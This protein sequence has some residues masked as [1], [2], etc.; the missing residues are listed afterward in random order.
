MSWKKLWWF[1]WKDDSFASLLVNILIA[2]VLIKFVVYPILGLILGTSFPVVAVVSCSMQHDATNCWAD[3][4]LKGQG[5]L[6]YCMNREENLCGKNAEKNY[7]GACGEWYENKGIT[8]DEFEEFPQKN[9]FNIGDI[10]VLKKAD[11]VEI[12]DVIVYNNKVNN[13][14][15]I[16][17]VVDI[18][19]GYYTTKGDHNSDT[20]FFEEKIAKEQVYGKVLLKIPYLGWVKVMFN[21]LLK[22]IGVI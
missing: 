2:I 11:S 21:I 14:P 18:K 6:N 13:A 9:G 5:N 8:K 16:H 4:Y 19:D 17:R 15:I 3:C 7:W 22:G 20:F 12:G 1:I 10:F